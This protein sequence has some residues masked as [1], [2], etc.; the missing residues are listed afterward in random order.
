MRTSSLLFVFIAAVLIA[1]WQTSSRAANP[2]PAGI[3]GRYALPGNAAV[4]FDLRPDGTFTTF[5]A[6]HTFSGSYTVNGTKVTLSVPNL[7]SQVVQVANGALIGPDGTKLPKVGPAGPPPSA[8][9]VASN[10]EAFASVDPMNRLKSMNNVKQLCIASKIWAA[11]HEGAF[12]DSIDRLLGP[13]YLGANPAAI[14]RCPLL[15]DDR[16]V[17][18]VYFGK[19]LKD[20]DKGD[21]IIFLSRW[22]NAQGQRIIGRADGAVVVEL[23]KV[24]NLPASVRATMRVVAK[25]GVGQSPAAVSTATG[26]TPAGNQTISN[27]AKMTLSQNSNGKGRYGAIFPAE[28]LPSDLRGY[29]WVTDRPDNGHN[30]TAFE[31]TV[32]KPNVWF[33]ATVPGVYRVRVE[34]RSGKVKQQVSNVLE[35]TVP[36]TAQ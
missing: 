35:V 19:G 2:A 8:A 12:P 18:Y 17:G 4:Y 30:V 13:K 27:L 32:L 9:Q 25:P 15:H 28:Q 29:Y 26:A 7:E 31:H 14:L 3:S 24:E 20:T 33:V 22:Q 11:D 10:A 5:Q 34:Y 1:N 21:T 36:N 23:V 6:A 16:Q